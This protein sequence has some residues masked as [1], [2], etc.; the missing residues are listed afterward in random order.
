MVLGQEEQLEAQ[1]LA[2]GPVLH[3]HGGDGVVVQM[4]LFQLQELRQGRPRDR[5]N[6]VLLQVEHADVLWEVHGE[7]V[8]LVAVKVDGVH[9]LDGVQLG[10]KPSIIDL[11]V[12][13]VEH[14]D[15]LR[16]PKRH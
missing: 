2:E 9:R 6:V 16:D 13:E 10:G 15:A 8:Q 14:G 5:L 7:F 12:M 11:V 3:A 4:E 1:R